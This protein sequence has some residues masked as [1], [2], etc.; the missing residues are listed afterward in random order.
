LHRED[1]KEVA[2]NRKLE[3]VE[4]EQLNVEKRNTNENQDKK[5]LGQE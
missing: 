4:Q 5:K 2:Q 3:V 1:R